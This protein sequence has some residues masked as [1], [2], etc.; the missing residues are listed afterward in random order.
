MKNNI[1]NEILKDLPNG[2]NA[3]DIVRGYIEKYNKTKNAYFAR[4]VF[5]ITGSYPDNIDSWGNGDAPR[6]SF[7]DYLNNAIY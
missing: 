5:E 7:A 1:Y 4:A 6:Q 2:T 3:R